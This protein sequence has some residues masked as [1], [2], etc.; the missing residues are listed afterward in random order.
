VE[1]CA[2]THPRFEHE[3]ASQRDLALLCLELS[4]PRSDKVGLVTTIFLYSGYSNCYRERNI[5][6]TIFSEQKSNTG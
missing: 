4:V 3:A 2:A 6:F 5:Y 1:L